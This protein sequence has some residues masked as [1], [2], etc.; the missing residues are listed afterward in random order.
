MAGRAGFEPATFGSG[1]TKM[2]GTPLK[3]PIE[4]SEPLKLLLWEKERLLPKWHNWAR[5]HLSE[6]TLNEYEKILKKYNT[7]HDLLKI[8]DSPKNHRLAF[9]S[10]AKFLHEENIIDDDIY[11][12]IKKLIKLKK[13]KIDPRIY[14]DD[15][16]K[17]ILS[18]A[19]N[20]KHQLY[21]RLV[22]ESGLR[23]SH[24]VEAFNRIVKKKYTIHGDIAEVQLNINNKTKRAFICLC[25][26]ELAE[27]IAKLG[28][29]MT[30]NVSGNLAKRKRVLYNAIRKWW[31]TTA[32]ENGMDPD[33]AD[34]IQG[35]SPS[36]IGVKHYLDVMRLSKKQYPAVL[37][38]IKENIYS[39]IR[40]ENEERLLAST[41]TSKRKRRNK[42]RRGR[43]R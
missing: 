33:V 43:K 15:E 31:Y 1:G 40:I 22:V 34:F 26:A 3:M 9:R 29:K 28:E 17:Q 42:R 19:P 36:S 35:R 25:S 5:Q 38:Y 41:H 21:L 18:L 13:T 6:K 32:R 23:R 20:R 11:T 14:S 10:L 37:S 12:K 8:N 2:G 27:E 16:I 39:G 4:K 7:V 24:A 30:Y